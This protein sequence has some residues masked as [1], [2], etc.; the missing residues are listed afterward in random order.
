MDG[1]TEMELNRFVNHFCEKLGLDDPNYREK[2]MSDIAPAVYYLSYCI[3]SDSQRKDILTNSQQFFTKT[4]LKNYT[5]SLMLF[6][7]QSHWGD[8]DDTHYA[9]IALNLW[10]LAFHK[11]SAK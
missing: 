3:M 6:M 1:V 10:C 4:L 2:A 9:I 8:E 5:Q 7:A 11:N